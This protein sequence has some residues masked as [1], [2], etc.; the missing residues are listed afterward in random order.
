MLKTKLV[1]IRIPEDALQVLEDY[2]QHN[3]YAGRCTVMAGI[4]KAVLT[5]ADTTTIDKMLYVQ[6]A[7]DNGYKTTFEWQP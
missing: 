7:A 2:C 3:P 5:T 6:N 4:L 1:S